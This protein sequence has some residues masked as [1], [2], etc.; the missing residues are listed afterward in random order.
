MLVLYILLTPSRAHINIILALSCICARCNRICVTLNRQSIDAVRSKIIDESIVLLSY[1]TMIYCITFGILE[2]RE[3]VCA[4]LC[5]VVT[6]GKPHA[7]L[8]S[9]P[10]VCLICV[11]S[12]CYAFLLLS[13]IVQ[14]RN[15]CA[16]W[17]LREMKSTSITEW[18]ES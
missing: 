13:C 16:R 1:D 2:I 12:H 17:T 6:I 8:S 14:L 7:L 3:D 18:M 4:S 15:E 9:S 5:V 11:S 10:C